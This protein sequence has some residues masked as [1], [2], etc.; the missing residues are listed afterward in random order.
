MAHMN[1]FTFRPVSTTPLFLAILRDHG[2]EKAF[3]FGRNRVRVE[4]GAGYYISGLN[5]DDRREWLDRLIDLAE[6]DAVMVMH[7]MH[8]L[9][10]YRCERGYDA[11]NREEG[12]VLAISPDGVVHAPLL[13]RG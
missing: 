5:R 1:R 3:R 8:F 2:P 4:E 6:V 12:T 7:I 10:H 9:Q 13:F 11:N